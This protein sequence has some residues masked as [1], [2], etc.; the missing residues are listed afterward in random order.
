VDETPLA[1][2]LV[3]HERR[4]LLPWRELARLV[5]RLAFA[6]ATDAGVEPS[7]LSVTAGVELLTWL[8]VVPH[9][10]ALLVE[11]L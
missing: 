6:G 11:A 8:S 7:A 4:R 10:R 1:R 2:G 9:V 5:N 3:V